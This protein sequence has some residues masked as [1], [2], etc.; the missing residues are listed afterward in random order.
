MGVYGM[1]QVGGSNERVWREIGGKWIGSDEGE[2]S[3]YGE[4]QRRRS[5]VGGKKKS[6]GVGIWDGVQVV[7]GIYIE[8]VR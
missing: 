2:E 8:G 1:E 5:I 6:D 3:V 7:G 4:Y